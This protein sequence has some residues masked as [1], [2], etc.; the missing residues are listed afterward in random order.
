MYLINDTVPETSYDR[1]LRGGKA[2]EAPAE[3]DSR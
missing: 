2:V 1:Y 3:E